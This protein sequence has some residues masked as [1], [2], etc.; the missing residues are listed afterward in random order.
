[1]EVAETSLIQ[2]GGDVFRSIPSSLGLWSSYSTEERGVVV[3]EFVSLD[4]GLQLRP[5]CSVPRGDIE[6]I[7]KAHFDL[8]KL[9]N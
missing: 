3:Y 2:C 9:A 7:L 5:D 8:T 1:M 6:Y 4:V